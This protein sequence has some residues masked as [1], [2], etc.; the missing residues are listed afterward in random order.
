MRPCFSTSFG[1]SG[2]SSFILE[3]VTS[4]SSKFFLGLRCPRSFLR[5]SIG[6]VGAFLR[7]MVE[8]FSLG[9]AIYSV[10]LVVSLSMTFGVQEVSSL[11]GLSYVLVFIVF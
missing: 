11:F 1:L 5:V 8:L 3:V 7:W 6:N 9:Y 4:K 2:A 10:W